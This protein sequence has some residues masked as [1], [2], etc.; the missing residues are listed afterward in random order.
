MDIEDLLKEP[1]AL[2][3][4]LLARAL[5]SHPLQDALELAKKGE[6][7]IRGETFQIG[8]AD[9]AVRSAEREPVRQ[10]DRPRKPTVEDAEDRK[11]DAHDK[12][13][14][15]IAHSPDDLVVMAT[16]DD[17]VRYFGQRITPVLSAGKTMF[18]VDG[19][20]RENASEL[21]ERANRIRRAQKLPSYALMPTPASPGT[22]LDRPQIAAANA[23]KA[24]PARPARSSDTILPWLGCDANGRPTDSNHPR[25]S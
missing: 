9:H 23:A 12:G 8:S 16:I 3:N 19:Q 7:F 21:V 11:R 25:F 14:D 6:A 22:K 17:V 24:P 15:P 20:H 5:K 18:L 2:R 1:S 4:W 10:A 13:A